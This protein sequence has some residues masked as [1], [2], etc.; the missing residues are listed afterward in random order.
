MG[1]LGVNGEILKK[2]SLDVDWIHLA[3]VADLWRAPVNILVPYK[4]GNFLVY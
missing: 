4:A 1:D 2:Q 3:V